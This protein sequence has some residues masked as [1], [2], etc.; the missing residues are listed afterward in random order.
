MD[1]FTS[2]DF[3]IR[4]FKE[5]IV[6]K[7]AIEAKGFSFLSGQKLFRRV[8]NFL[9]G[10]EFV[11]DIES[12]FQ[13]LFSFQEYIVK[14]SEELTTFLKNQETHFLAVTLPDVA[15]VEEVLS[16]TTH[17]EQQ[18]IN[19]GTLMVNRS[20]PTWLV[21]ESR[22]D[23]LDQDHEIKKYYHLA[24]TYYESRLQ[25][26]Q[27]LVKSKDH[28]IQIYFLPENTQELESKGVSGI[29]ENLI[30]AFEEAQ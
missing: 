8:Y 25:Q 3:V 26:V 2:P 5:N 13:I 10:E 27:Q 23:F 7:A 4:L 1:F 20:Y 6:A 29:S 19:V 12:F 18:G 15:K 17:L 16:V 21:R 9:V 22:V 11:K 14:S 30:R 24:H 28:D